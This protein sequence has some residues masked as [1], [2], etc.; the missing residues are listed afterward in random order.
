MRFLFLVIINCP[1][2]FTSNML[3]KSNL[4]VGRLKYDGKHIIQTSLI[5]S[6]KNHYKTTNAI[7]LHFNEQTWL[8]VLVNSFVFIVNCCICLELSKYLYIVQYQHLMNAYLIFKHYKKTGL[9]LC[10]IVT[11][12]NHMTEEYCHVKT[13]PD[14]PIRTAVRMS[15]A[16]PG[17]IMTFWTFFGFYSVVESNDFVVQSK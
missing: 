3:F 11:N 2:D 16:I 8:N 13:T 1:S 5:N 7:L 4:K 9:E 15:M 14:M 17:N 6:S 12:V 10:I